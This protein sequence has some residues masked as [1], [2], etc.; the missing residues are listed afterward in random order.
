MGKAACLGWL[1]GKSVNDMEKA[2]SFRMITA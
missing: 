1:Q 2:T